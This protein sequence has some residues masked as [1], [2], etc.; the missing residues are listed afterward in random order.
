M[1]R[2]DEPGQEK[3][4]NWNHDASKIAPESPWE[5]WM[6][7]LEKETTLNKLVCLGYIDRLD[8]GLH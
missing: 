5:R 2:F 1:I 8:G 7:G 4:G 3:R 6:D